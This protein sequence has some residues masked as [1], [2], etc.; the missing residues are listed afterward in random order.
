MTRAVAVVVLLAIATA[1]FANGGFVVTTGRSTTIDIPGATSAYAIDATIAEVSVRNGIV[2]LTGRSAGT[3]QIVVITMAGSYTLPVTVQ[4]A[5][6]KKPVGVES[7]G[8]RHGAASAHYA[9]S[10]GATQ[11]QS[12]VDLYEANGARKTEVHLLDEQDSGRRFAGQPS[13]YVRNATVRVTTPKRTLTLFD[14]TVQNSPLTLDGTIV[15]GVHLQ[16]GAWRLHAGYTSNALF[17]SLLIPSRRELVF[18][19]SYLWRLSPSSTLMPS[20]FAYPTRPADASVVR[21]HGV[22]SM[23]YDF[24]PSDALHARAEVGWGGTL[25]T[26]GQLAWDG[27]HDRLRADVRYEPRGF[28]IVGPIDIHGLYS[29]ASWSTRRGR[30]SADVDASANRFDLTR[31]TERTNT[32]NAQ[33]SYAVTRRTSLLSGIMYG[34]FNGVAT[35]RVPL[36]LQY[37]R[38]NFGGSATYFAGRTSGAGRLANG[39]RL[40][41]HAS[42]GAFHVNGWFDRQ[43]DTP[44]LDLILRDD[45][46]LALAL[47][48]LGIVATSPQDIARALRENAALINLGFIE[49]VTVNLAPLRRQAGV[50]ASWLGVGAA[51]RQL[52]FRLLR[53]EIES[54]SGRTTT[55][56]ATLT[57]AQHLSGSTE[58]F[59]GVSLLQTRMNGQRTPNQRF[60][61]AGI[62][63]RFDDLPRFGGGTIA[64]TV[65]AD[66]V[67]N[68]S[69]LPG[70]KGLDGIAV[71]LDG[72]SQTRSD[73]NGNYAFRAVGAGVHRLTVRAGATSYFTT[74]SS[75][76][77]EAP[78]VVN[79]GIAASPAHLIGHVLDD[80]GAGLGGVTVS[81]RSNR[82]D[83]GATSMTDGKFSIAAVPGE[84][85]LRIATDTLPSGYSMAGPDIMNVVLDP[86]SP[87]E[88]TFRVRANRSISGIATPNAR[89]EIPRL[90]RSAVA[91][92]Q[93]HFV[94]RGLPAG[95]LTLVSGSHSVRLTLP[96]T[97]A[98]IDNVSL[99]TGR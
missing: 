84:Y 9:S 83:V 20:I 50:E 74:P 97:P 36:G 10:G 66:D 57:Y 62:R 52:R 87:K 44:T 45:P 56:I 88:A 78:V 77:V 49:G 7:E 16:Q 85:E 31:F 21:A 13:N 12:S 22:A 68:G 73:R 5:A 17:G 40:S 14:D 28:A 34:S 6:A 3:T 65:F 43:T 42:A 24:S 19:G 69:L 26:A 11:I 64:G 29:D 61:E 71:D 76:D 63:Q 94:F 39:F 46:A 86:A 35:T 47:E 30:F 75:V 81:I 1:A 25:G 93:G 95:E 41:A 2:S 51:Q 82:R 99:V 98:V 4:A 32:A 72:R 59:A 60:V 96:A 23:A 48:E 80:T 79:F 15:R 92:A 38:F 70:A 33:L 37:E 27:D 58:A 89:I 90:F 8:P 55:S 18:G 91:D 53:N 67:M 54:V